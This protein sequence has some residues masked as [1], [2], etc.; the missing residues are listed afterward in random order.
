MRGRSWWVSLLAVGACFGTGHNALAASPW[1]EVPSPDRGTGANELTG[2]A[3]VSATDAWAVGPGPQLLRWN[4]ASWS[5]VTLPVALRA[6]QLNAISAVSASNVW[7][8]GSA[9]LHFNGTKWSSGPIPPP[10]LQ[11]T[12]VSATSS[13]NVWVTAT[14]G[15]LNVDQTIWLLR[16]NGSSWETHFSLNAGIDSGVRFYGVKSFSASNTWAVYT[17]YGPSAFGGHSIHWNGTLTEENR[18]DYI[19]DEFLNDFRGVAGSGPGNIWEV[20]RYDTYGGT[21]NSSWG[22]SFDGATW[23]TR[24]LPVYSAGAHVLT[25]VA[26]ASKS[27]VWAGGYRQGAT[28]YPVKVYLARWDGVSW[29]EYGGPN[30]ASGNNGVN[31][32]NAVAR[33]PGT[34]QFWAVGVSGDA[35]T[36][37]TM[38]LRCC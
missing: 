3:P 22:A 26:P 31:Q 36:Q 19:F 35:T 4:G 38:I 12:G 23:T 21:Y 13:T 9:V 15:N 10:G 25:G 24:L 8:V 20:G 16:W 37:H 6:V 34:R 30:P 29:T 14:S 5:L 7:A 32:V 33:V 28:Q 17:F 27:L 11:L 18:R 1:I 2:I